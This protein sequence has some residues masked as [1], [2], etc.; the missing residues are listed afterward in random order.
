[1]SKREQS[2]DSFNFSSGKLFLTLESIKLETPVDE[3]F[4]A[5][6]VNDQS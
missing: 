6:I 1:M 4:I 5:T 2:D 3:F